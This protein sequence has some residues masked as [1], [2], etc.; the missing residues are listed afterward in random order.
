VS[1]SMADLLRSLPQESDDAGEWSAADTTNRADTLSLRPVP[2]GRLRRIGLLATLQ[3][4]I[5]AAYLFH[6]IRGWFKPAGENERLLAETHWRT[7]LRLLDSMHYMRG[8]MMKIGQTL[9]NLPD[10][11]PREF[12]ETLQSLHFNAPPMHWSLMREM[13]FRELGDD[14]ENVFAEFDTTAFAAASLGQVHR[15]RLRTGEEVAVKVQYPGIAR[16]IRDDFRN[17][18]MLL[19]PARLG[20]DWDSTKG[21]LDELRLQLEQETDYE[22]EATCL[23]KARSLFRE[24]DGIVV[25]RVYRE[26]TTARVLTMEYVRGAHLDAYLAGN[27]PQHERNAFAAKLLTSWYRLL[28]AGRMLYAD[29]H[30][31]N[32]LFMEDGRLGMLDFGFVRRIP[33]A[34]W[35]WYRKCDRAITTGDRGDIREAIREWCQITDPVAE[36]ERFELTQEYAHV[37]WQPRFYGGEFDFG[38]EGHFRRPCDMFME[39]AGKRYTRAHSS[40]PITSRL[41]FGYR[42]ILYRLKAKVNVRELAEREVRSS[43]WDRGDYA[44]E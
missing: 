38:D 31:G 29:F 17:L 13:V 3:A 26:F 44:P 9:A 11:A 2:V 33:D 39:M 21:Q 7:A 32:L 27:P 34:E 18:L 20:K 16:T 5:A 8:A 19:L 10:I 43:G 42:S 24:D 25:P 28:Y 4:K 15:A 36:R 22:R 23:W 12:V 41:E 37:V 6:W 14:P 35:E 1:P 40:T 30:P